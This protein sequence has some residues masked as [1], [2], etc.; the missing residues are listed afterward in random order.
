MSTHAGRNTRLY[1]L[2]DA[3][4]RTRND[5]TWGANVTHVATGP[6]DGPLCSSSWIHAYTHPLIAVLLNPVHANFTS[7]RL[8]VARG[9]V[10]ATAHD[11]KVGC[12]SL[13]TIKETPLPQI[14]ITQ[15][16]AF[17]ILCALAVY[18]DA[19]FTRW[20]KNWLSGSD[21]SCA[22]A[23]VASNVAANV[24]AYASGVEACMAA[25]AAANAAEASLYII[26][27]AAQ[28]ADAANLAAKTAESLAVSLAVKTVAKLKPNANFSLIRI[29]KRAMEVQ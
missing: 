25:Q 4:C 17:G 10:G 9:V 19:D 8:F 3:Q 28:A 7:P 23:R 18:E 14:N 21:R 5:T 20:A 27:A 11:L 13:T 26:H 24:A 15:K 6:V 22:S 2:T 29:A 16:V 1:K 12:R